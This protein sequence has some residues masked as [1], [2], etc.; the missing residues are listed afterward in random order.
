MTATIRSEP[1]PVAVMP[2]PTKAPTTFYIGAA[3][4][5]FSLAQK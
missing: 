1:F 2:V 4:E 5:L 3:F